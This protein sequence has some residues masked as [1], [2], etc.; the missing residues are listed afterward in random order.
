MSQPASDNQLKWENLHKTVNHQFCS[1]VLMIFGELDL[2]PEVSL[3][4]VEQLNALS[5]QSRMKIWLEEWTSID[6][7]I[8]ETMTKLVA[9]VTNV[10]EELA[11]ELGKQFPSMMDDDPKI[12]ASLQTLST[13]ESSDKFDEVYSLLKESLQ[14]GLNFIEDGSVIDHLEGN[15]FV[16]FELKARLRQFFTSKLQQM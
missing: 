15:P 10:D 16:K 6:N 14:K 2:P 12:K 1:E 4:L 11:E 5:F 3:L 9:A 13:V 8:A 7:D